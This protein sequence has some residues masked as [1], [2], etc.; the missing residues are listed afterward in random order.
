MQ[1]ALITA[2]IAHGAIAARTGHRPART[3]DGNLRAPQAA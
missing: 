2:V 1:S 3:P